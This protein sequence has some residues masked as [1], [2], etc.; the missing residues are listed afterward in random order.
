MVDLRIG[1]NL[2][3]YMGVKPK[4]IGVGDLIQR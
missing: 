3:V 4:D 1:V 2:M